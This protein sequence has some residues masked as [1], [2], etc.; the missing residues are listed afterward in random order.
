MPTQA[1]IRNRARIP[2]PGMRPAAP[3]SGRR[4]PSTAT[5]AHASS[6]IVAATGRTTARPRK[7]GCVSRA[8]MKSRVQAA[9]RGPRTTA[10]AGSARARDAQAQVGRD[11]VAPEDHERASASRDEIDGQA[12]REARVLGRLLRRVRR[13]GG[14]IDALAARRVAVLAEPEVD[15][16]LRAFL[17]P[18]NVELQGDFR[19]G[20]HVHDE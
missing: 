19:R 2:S 8:I 17:A 18:G 11:P 7:M 1:A 16:L 15:D 3:N 6:E 13:V 20:L 10:A 12:Q 5:K 4:S 9:Y 14:R